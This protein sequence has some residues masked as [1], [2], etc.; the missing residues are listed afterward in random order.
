MTK[1]VRAN[2]FVLDT[3]MYKVGEDAIS[4]AFSRA[5][6]AADNTQVPTF[7]SP[8]Q[9]VQPFNPRCFSVLL[10]E[11]NM[12]VEGNMDVEHSCVLFVGRI[13]FYFHGGLPTS[14]LYFSRRI[15][16]EPHMEKNMKKC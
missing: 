6:D 14:F 10:G 12:D 13:I 4:D 1:L 7:Q 2:K 8:I 16:C 9:V 5:A 11:P 15:M 3:V